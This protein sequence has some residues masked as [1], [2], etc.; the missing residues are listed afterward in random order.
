MD[1]ATLEPLATRKAIQVPLGIR[2]LIPDWKT[3]LAQPV[4]GAT[5]ALILFLV[6]QAGLIQVGEML[7]PAAH[8]LIGCV[9]GCSEP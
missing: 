9:R 3:F 5:T 7:G 6:F 4:I 1:V 8:G 2:T